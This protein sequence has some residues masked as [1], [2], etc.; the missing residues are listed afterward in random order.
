MSDSESVASREALKQNLDT[1]KA[2]LQSTLAQKAAFLQQ[3]KQHEAN[4]LDSQIKV[5]KKA[6]GAAVKNIMSASVRA[7][8]VE[9]AAGGGSQGS[10]A[11]AAGAVGRQELDSRV[12]LDD[13]RSVPS[14]ALE[15]SASPR[16]GRLRRASGVVLD[17]ATYDPSVRFLLVAAA[18]F[19]V[20]LVILLLS[21]FIT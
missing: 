8:D 11:S 13:G 10:P 20:F 14:E 2:A 6:L 17:E 9:A 18:L 21:K 1:L 4:Q 7:P 15:D 3:G 16:A 5:H 19:V 12:E